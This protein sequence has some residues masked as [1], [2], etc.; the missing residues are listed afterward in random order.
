M[1]DFHAL[2]ARYSRDVRALA[3]LLTGDPAL[4][5]DV[6]SE[7]FVRAWTASGPIR[8]ET[9]K[10]YLLT[11]A[12]HLI[13][14]AMRRARRFAVLDDR[15]ATP[16]ASAERQAE[17]NQALRVV[18]E[19]MKDLPAIDRAALLMRAQQD[20]SYEEIAQS[21]GISLSSV[22][23]KIHRARLRLM[24]ARDARN[25]PAKPPEEHE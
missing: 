6:T 5:D 11:I 21:L 22:K 14:D 18:L 9:V 24:Q 10:A 1:S 3:L 25:R 8:D 2:Y 15:M 23:V 13:Q 17:A 19:A 12:R 16:A 7:T 4:A 20:M